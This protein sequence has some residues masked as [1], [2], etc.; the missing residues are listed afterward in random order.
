M[1][2]QMEAMV[3]EVNNNIAK[4]KLSRHND[5]SH[6]GTCPGNSAMLLEANNDIGAR[7]GERVVMV[8]E[9]RNVL[10]SAFIVYILPILAGSLGWI[11]GFYM[12]QWLGTT[13][14]WPEMIGSL[15]FLGLALFYIVRFEKALSAKSHIPV[16]IQ[17]NH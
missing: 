15:A 14:F 7:P 5:C 9:D 2:N 6:C 1:K 11:A 10:Q 12:A 4:V 8:V 3:V 13:T 16:L 17:N